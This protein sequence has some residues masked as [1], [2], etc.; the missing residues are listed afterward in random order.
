MKNEYSELKYIDFCKKFHSTLKKYP[1][2]ECAYNARYAYKIET[3]KYRKIGGKWHEVTEEKTVEIVP[4]SFYMNIIDAIPF[5]RNL[6]GSERVTM[7]YTLC[8]YI[9]VQLSS[10]SPDGREKVLRRFKP[11]TI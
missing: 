9:P 6:G 1:G 10:I 5:F 8:G 4:G 11:V 3:T 2:M 7:G